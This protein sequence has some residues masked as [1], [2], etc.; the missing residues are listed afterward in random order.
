[1]FYFVHP[2]QELKKA[3]EESLEKRL[4]GKSWSRRV[5]IKYRRILGF[6]VPA[7]L[8]H[9]FWWAYFIKYNTWYL[10]PDK[11]EMTITMIFGSLI[12]GISFMRPVL[13]S[14]SQLSSFSMLHVFVFEV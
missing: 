12:A 14:K 7:I 10:F 6:C 1:M 4:E 11:Y 8:F 3:P 13:S 5:L 9:L 2:G